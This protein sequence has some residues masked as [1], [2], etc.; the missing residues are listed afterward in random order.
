MAGMRKKPTSPAL[1][2]MLDEAFA[3]ASAANVD[4]AFAFYQVATEILEIHA[5]LSIP[6]QRAPKDPWGGLKTN[7]S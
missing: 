4:L 5:R 3:R 1:E 7:A 2:S 6:S